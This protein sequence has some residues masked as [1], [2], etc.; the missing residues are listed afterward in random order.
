MA[1]TA[2]DGTSECLLADG[3]QERQE[4]GYIRCPSTAHLF[5]PILENDHTCAI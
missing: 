3:W 4:R 1:L 2:A 5:S